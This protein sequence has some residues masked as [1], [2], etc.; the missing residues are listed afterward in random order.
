MMIHDSMASGI[1]HLFWVHLGTF[2]VAGLKVLS[3]GRVIAIVF[4]E[5]LI[6]SGGFISHAEVESRVVD[7]F[8]EYP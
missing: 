5:D 2:I 7:D 6:S 3:G 1:S 4:E 8:R